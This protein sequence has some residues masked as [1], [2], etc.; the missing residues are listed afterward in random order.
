MIKK[1]EKIVDD[2]YGKNKS[3]EFLST[4]LKY[5]KRRIE[6]DIEYISA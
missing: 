5:A 1:F 3:S 4:N 2:N 6:D